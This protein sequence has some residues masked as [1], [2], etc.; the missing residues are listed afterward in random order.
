[1][2]QMAALMRPTLGP[3]PRT[4]A[5]APVGDSGPPEILDSAATIARRTLQLA[6]PFEDMGAMIIRHLA[7]RVFEQ[8]GDGAATAAVLAC[9]LVR[10]AMPCLAAGCSQAALRRGI[11]RGLDI[12]RVELRRQAHSIE[13][14]SEIAAVALGAVADQKLAEL[15]GET[16][17][18]VGT[19]GAILFENAAG[20]ETE[21]EYVDGVRW[22]EG[23]LSNF[24]LKDGESTARLLGPRILATDIPVE[25]AEQLVPALEVCASAGERSL[26]VIAPE[27]RD[28]A[29]GML[30]LNRQR[31]VLDSAIAVKAPSFGAQQSGI[32]ED[33]AVLTGGRC[34]HA[35]RGDSLV[36]IT[37]HDL[38]RARHAWATRNAFGILGGGGAREQIRERIAAV[39]AELHVSGDDPNARDKL[40]ERIGKLAGTT[41]IIRVGAPAPAEQAELRLRMEAAVTAARLAVEQGVVAGGGSA[42]LACVPALQAGPCTDEEGLGIRILA[43]SLGEPMRTLVGNA[44]FEPEPIVHEA[45]RRDA[46]W[47]FDVLRAEWVD[48]LPCGLVDPLAVTLAALETSVSAASSVLSAEVLIAHR[49]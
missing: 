9:A 30:V 21:S 28:S 40:K 13:L 15:I 42:L 25:R 2:G 31:G 6:D 1:M 36:A 18:S 8:V 45:R 38:G 46:G 23:Y 47:A 29:V 19:D 34:L 17:D 20:P 10:E 39:K 48:A 4:V 27:M 32:L 22:N 43:R 37:D 5:I 24:L 11:E 16:I 7:L 41:A 14:P 35:E 33:I 3:V 44:G 49:P 26:L 12:V